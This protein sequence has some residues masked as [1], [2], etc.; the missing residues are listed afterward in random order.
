MSEFEIVNNTVRLIGS[1]PP[2]MTVKE[3][4]EAS[5]QKWQFIADKLKENPQLDLADRACRTCALCWGFYKING[6]CYRCPVAVQTGIW[7]CSETPYIDW[8]HDS[9]Y[10]NAL[11]E[12]RFLE[13]LLSEVPTLC[14]LEQM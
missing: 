5:I 8:L 9:T 12:V 4:I 3:R 2:D 11:K 1:F 13:T 14:Q 10:Q 7:G 6:D